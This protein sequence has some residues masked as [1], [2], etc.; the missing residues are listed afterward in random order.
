MNGSGKSERQRKETSSSTT[1]RPRHCT[2]IHCLHCAPRR[3]PY[4]PKRQCQ[5][6]FIHFPRRRIA[7]HSANSRF[8]GFFHVWQSRPYAKTLTPV[9]TCITTAQRA[10][11]LEHRRNGL[12]AA[13]LPVPTRVVKAVRKWIKSSSNSAQKR[14]YALARHD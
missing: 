3:F 6:D 10:L 5:L 4:S 7:Q 13:T 1:S 2:T 8:R 12:P 11:C 14:L 9:V